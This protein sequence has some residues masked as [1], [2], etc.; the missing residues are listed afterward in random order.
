M[1]TLGRK[2]G[3]TGVLSILSISFFPERDE[4]GKAVIVRTILKDYV[5]NQS[6]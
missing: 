3:N 2:P 6:S 1:T 4:A 5:S